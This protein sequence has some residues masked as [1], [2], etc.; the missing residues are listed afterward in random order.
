MVK[1]YIPEQ[2]DV[3]LLD[4]NPTKGHEQSG[5]RPAVV[6]SNNIFNEN[7]KMVIVCP[8]T[9]NDKEFPT[10]YRLEDTKNIKGSVLCEH[11]RSIDYETRKLK[12]I[13]KTSDNDFISIITLL[14]A[15]IEE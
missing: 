13:E 5:F 12:F 9:S 8:I 15:C 7:T 3:V 6:I 10:H 11:I 4:F 1:K 2:G 14:N